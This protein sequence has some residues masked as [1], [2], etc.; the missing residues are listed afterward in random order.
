MQACVS[1]LTAE[2]SRPAQSQAVISNLLSRLV[3]ISQAVLCQILAEFK[4]SV[5]SW[6][7]IAGVSN[8]NQQLELTKAESC[9]SSEMMEIA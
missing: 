7:K 5:S 9:Q 4:L 6:I 3:N 2:D 8:N 1:I